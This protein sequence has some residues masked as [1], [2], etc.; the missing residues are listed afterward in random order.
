MISDQKL[1]EIRDSLPA[2][3]WAYFSGCV[4]KGFTREEALSVLKCWIRI[5]HRSP[6]PDDSGNI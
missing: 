4:D 3:W 6:P 2:I 1:A 5:T